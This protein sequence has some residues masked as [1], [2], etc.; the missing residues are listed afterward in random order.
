MKLYAGIDLHS[1]NNYLGIIDEGDRRVFGKKLPNDLDTILHCL[2]PFKEGLM[3]AVVESTFNWYWLADGLMMNGYKIHLANPGAIQQYNG[4]KY[5]DDKWDS[6]WL[7]HMLRL[8]ILPEGYIYPR[9][10]R[11][12]RDLLRNRLKLVRE[13]T[14]HV[15]SLKSMICRNLG[16]NIPGNSVKKFKEEDA[17]VLFDQ[18]QMVM[19]AKVS[20]SIMQSLSK[21]I[22]AIEKEVISKISLKKAFQCLLSVPGI[23][24]TLALTIMLEVGDINRFKKVGNFSSYCRCVTT[25]RLSN[26][27]SKGKGNSKNGNKYLSWA[28]VEAANFAKRHCPY[29]QSF[30]QRKYNKGGNV[31]AIKA[32]SNKLARATYYIMRDQEQYNPRMLFS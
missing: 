20:I 17:E 18:P 30:Y 11:P 5:T 27:K 16:I 2:N 10:E 14:S 29:A 15:L 25:N 13:K 19:R 7:A 31:L 23:G 1:T 6:F 24:D 4:L 3:G 9:K 26:G 8:N 21:H 28:Y 32:L 22:D 12:L